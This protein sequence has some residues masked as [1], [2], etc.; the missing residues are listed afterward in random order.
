MN[1]IEENP[2]T[3]LNGTMEIARISDWMY[4]NKTK[5]T[6]QLIDQNFNDAYDLL[7]GMLKN[8]YSNLIRLLRSYYDWK[9][10]L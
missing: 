9:Q 1:K 4:R 7:T 5:V 8:E 6:Y 10:R 3:F 2:T